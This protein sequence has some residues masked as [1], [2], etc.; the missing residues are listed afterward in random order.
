MLLVAFMYLFGIDADPL[1]KNNLTG[2]FLSHF[3]YFVS[4]P[5]L[6]VCPLRTDSWSFV[7][8]E[9]EAALRQPRVVNL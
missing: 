5:L 8:K 3:G 4:A 2:Y 9:N 1:H 7:G 6:A